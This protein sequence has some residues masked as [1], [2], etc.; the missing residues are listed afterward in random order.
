MIHDLKLALRSLAGAKRLSA[1]VVVTLALGLGANTAVFG[2]LN[3]A[4][5]QPLPYPDPDRL[6]RIYEAADD[7]LPGPVVVALRD[8]SRTVDVAALYTYSPEGADL[9]DRAQPERVRTLAVGADYFRVLS[10]APALGRLFDRADERSDAPIAIVSDRIWRDH[11]DAAR[12]ADGRLLT[13]N[14]KAYRVAAVLPEGFDDPLEPGIDIWMPLNLQ[15]G[16]PNNWDNF[17]LSAIAR[18]RPGATLRQA[19]AEL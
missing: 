2:V 12:D 4:V 3:A 10:V 18:L 11:L 1:V 6:V 17:Y 13:L 15:S 19:Q 14:G 5:L 8:S 16:G 7:Y 9:T